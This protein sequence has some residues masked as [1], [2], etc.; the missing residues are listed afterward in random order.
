M[1]HAWTNGGHTKGELEVEGTIKIYSSIIL[2][3]CFFCL[4]KSP[5]I[6]SI[7]FS[8]GFQM[9]HLEK[10][11]EVLQDIADLTVKATD[12]A[13]FKCEVSDD[14]VTGKWF[15]DGV[16]V[17]PSNRIKMT[18][19][20]RCSLQQECASLLPSAHKVYTHHF[21]SVIQ[22]RFHRLI[23]DDVKPEDAGDYTFVP[24]GYALSLSAKLNF[25]GEEDK[26]SKLKSRRKE[27]LMNFSFFF[28]RQ[29]K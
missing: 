9:V 24:D 2:L 8:C 5:L 28:S 20:G 27:I 16:E 23:I 6:K 22:F 21:F 10:Q 26:I 15:K 12:Q 14:K 18:H 17:L 19:I 11:L 1:Y 29:Q 3:L 25:L 13:M 4:L 7:L